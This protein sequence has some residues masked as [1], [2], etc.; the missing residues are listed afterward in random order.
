M[1][2]SALQYLNS[3]GVLI[4]SRR[5]GLYI[6]TSDY[7][8]VLK[9]TDKQA[10]EAF[11]HKKHIQITHGEDYVDQPLASLKTKPIPML[12]TSLIKFDHDI[13]RFHLLFYPINYY[14]CFVEIN[15][16]MTRLVSYNRKPFT[17][18]TTRISVY[19]RLMMSV[20]ASRGLSV[21]SLT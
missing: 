8:Y 14:N 21:P 18:K 20:F 16:L 4:G 5:F 13:K 1:T 19:N 12:N 15:Y 17:D 3:T 10:V 2:I 6:L 11:F 7:D 9:N